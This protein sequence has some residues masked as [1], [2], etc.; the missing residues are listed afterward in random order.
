[1]RKLSWMT[2]PSQ[3]QIRKNYLALFSMTDCRAA[4]KKKKKKKINAYSLAA[5]AAFWFK[6]AIANIH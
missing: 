4:T 2:L 1:M 6:C 3:I 5:A